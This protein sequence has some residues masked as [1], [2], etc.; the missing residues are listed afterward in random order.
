MSK[1]LIQCYKLFI[2]NI[3]NRSKGILGET[4]I[5]KMMKKA[6][7]LSLDDGLR[8][9][10][11]IE[12]NQGEVQL[13]MVNKNYS[14]NKAS[15]TAEIISKKFNI[16]IELINKALTMLVGKDS[17]IKI[18]KDSLQDVIVN[19]SELFEKEKFGTVIPQ[20]IV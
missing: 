1:D 14:E 15:Y 13:V 20:F 8:L 18:L 3:F 19:N 9:L 5:T 7:K 16:I 10:K 6:E 11:G 4:F 12:F 17:S 2:D